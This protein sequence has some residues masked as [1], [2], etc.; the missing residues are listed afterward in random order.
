MDKKPLKSNV[1]NSCKRTVKSSNICNRRHHME[2]KGFNKGVKLGPKGTYVYRI[3]VAGKVKTGDTAMRREFEAINEL[4]K[5]RASFLQ[6]SLGVEKKKAPT[7]SKGI[8]IWTEKKTGIN[9]ATYIHNFTTALKL[10]FEPALGHKKID[11]ISKSDLQN[12]L[13]KYAQ[14]SQGDKEVKCFGGYNKLVSILHNFFALMRDERYLSSFDLP[15]FEESQEKHYDVLKKEDLDKLFKE[16]F[17][18]YGLQRAVA[19]AMGCYLGLRASEISNAQWSFIDWEEKKFCNTKTKNKK[20]KPIPICDDMLDWFKRLQTDGDMLKVGLILVNPEG[21]AYPRRYTSCILEK[22]GLEVFKK[23]LTPHSLRRSFITI[24]HNGGT[25]PR[26]LQELARHASLA[27]TM[28]YVKIGEEE[29]TK[30]IDDVF[31]HKE[32]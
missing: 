8:E 29:K 30:A 6:D 12:C 31:N 28:H 14:K 3:K 25:P 10:H 20:N 32:A 1:K 18:R 11:K 24:L 26:T 15:E 7:F 5:I 2:E 21:G 23:H 13:I 19:V 9:D 17:S 16:V 4:V 27:Q 22:I